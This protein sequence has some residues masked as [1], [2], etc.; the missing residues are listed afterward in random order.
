MRLTTASILHA[1]L[2]AFYAS[3]EQRDNPKLRG[4]AMSVGGDIV[5]AASYEARAMGVKT[6]MNIRTAR[7]YCPDLITVE[8]RMHAYSQASHEV[9]EIFDDTSPLVEAISIDEAFIDVGGLQKLIGSPASI[10]TTLRKRV[11]EEFG[12]PISVGIA[13]TKS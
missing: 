5:L 7:R 13:R 4:K 11:L 9:F 12:L 3:V 10:A 1:D 6:P 2:D 8:P